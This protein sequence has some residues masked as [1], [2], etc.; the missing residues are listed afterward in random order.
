MV[1]LPLYH[2]QNK[3][4][5]LDPPPKKILH[6]L[7]AFC[8]D[9][10]VA[11]DAYIEMKRPSNSADRAFLKAMALELCALLQI[12][13]HFLGGH[14]KVNGKIVDRNFF[15]NILVSMEYSSRKGQNS[16]T[17]QNKF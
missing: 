5:P 3:P 7:I 2:H 8:Y 9:K 12:K 17:T 14:Q 6:L 10:E 15:N 16:Y 4:Q 13:N 11:K 1:Q